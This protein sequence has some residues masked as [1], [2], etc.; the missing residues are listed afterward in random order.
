MSPSPDVVVYFNPFIWRET[1]PGSESWSDLLKATKVVWKELEPEATFPD[2]FC[3]A[4]YHTPLPGTTLNL[5]HDTFGFYTGT[6]L[7]QPQLKK[8]FGWHLSLWVSKMLPIWILPVLLE[9][10]SLKR[11]RIEIGMTNCTKSH[12]KSQEWCPRFPG[13]GR[14]VPCAGLSPP[15]Y[16]TALRA[17]VPLLLFLFPTAKE[18]KPAD[19]EDSQAVTRDTWVLPCLHRWLLVWL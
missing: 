7:N 1:A 4:L 8:L 16:P 10:Q 5:E 19:A 13:K 12:G 17:W 6:P 2:S 15:S 3:V 18:E 9:D 11:W 14:A